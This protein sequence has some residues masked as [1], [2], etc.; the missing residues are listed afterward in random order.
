MAYRKS[1]LWCTDDQERLINPYRHLVT[2]KCPFGI[3]GAHG[4]GI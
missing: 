3:D 2:L 4:S 1:S